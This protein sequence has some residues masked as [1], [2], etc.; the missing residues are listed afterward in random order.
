LRI[1]PIF[2]G[3]FLGS[4]GIF[5]ENISAR[6]G[7]AH[8]QRAV[9]KKGN[10]ATHNLTIFGHVTRSKPPRQGKSLNFFEKILPYGHIDM[11]GTYVM[12]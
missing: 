7:N 3:I 5:A 4:R 1:L 11:V 9:E 12:V 10:K 6:C 8:N 2:T